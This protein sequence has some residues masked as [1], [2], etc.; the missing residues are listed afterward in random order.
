MAYNGGM[1]GN[2]SGTPSE[3]VYDM[4]SK[5]TSKIMRDGPSGIGDAI[6]AGITITDCHKADRP[7]LTRIFKYEDGRNAEVVFTLYR[8]DGEWNGRK[9]SVMLDVPDTTQTPVEDQARA[10]LRDWVERYLNGVEGAEMI[11]V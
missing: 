7:P 6:A 1:N 10:C 9:I 4:I 11:F 3:N 8:V 5:W 2:G